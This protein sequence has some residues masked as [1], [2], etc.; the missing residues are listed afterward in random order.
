MTLS[1]SQLRLLAVVVVLLLAAPAGL[2][3]LAPRLRHAH[4]HAQAPVHH[5]AAPATSAPA[6]AAPARVP[7]SAARPQ[8][9]SEQQP[10]E[11][12][13]RVLQRN[14][15][16][17]VAL[18]APGVELDRLALVQAAAGARQAHAGF[19]AVDV[20][21]EASARWVAARYHRA[22]EPGVLVLSGQRLL[23]QLFGYVDQDFVAQAALAR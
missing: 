14:R 18:Y 20:A 10:P 13:L 8:Q 3:V 11:N 4:V 17:V 23:G 1:P 16:V 5:A 2:L 7:I 22:T 15:V 12:V 21:D 6:P 19:A 9:P